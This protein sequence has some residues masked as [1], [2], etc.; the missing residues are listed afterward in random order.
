MPTNVFDRYI[1]TEIL[2]A[3]PVKLVNLLYRGALDSVAAAR[4]HLAGGEILERSRQI[5]RAWEIVQELSETLN[6]EQGGEVSRNLAELYHYIQVRLLQANA[7]QADA[8]LAEA[9][10]LLATLA[11][12]WREVPASAA[13]VPVAS[14]YVPVACSA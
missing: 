1:E 14:E 3:D 8:P 5:T 13:P 10:T 2:S 11:E 4:R 12:A 9:E 7:Q 6:H